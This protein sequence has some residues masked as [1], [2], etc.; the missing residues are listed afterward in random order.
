MRPLPEL[1]RGDIATFLDDIRSGKDPE[2][3]GVISLER[4]R[5]ATELLAGFTELAPHLDLVILD[6]AHALRNKNS[7]SY[8]AWRAIAE[9]AEHVVFLSAT[10]LNLGTDDLFNLVNLLDPDTFPDSKVFQAQL[11]PNQHLNTVARLMADPQG[12][13]HESALRELQLLK[14]TAEGEAVAKRPSF[15]RLIELL[16]SKSTSPD[17]IARIKRYT[18]E[19]NTLGSVFTRTRKV[20]VPEA[21]ALR[22]VEEVLVTW[23]EQEQDLYASIYRLSMRRARD[24]GLPL[25]FAMQMPL[26]QACSSLVVAQRRQLE[27]R[28]WDFRDSDE[29]D[30]EQALDLDADLTE[31]RTIGAD[32]EEAL[33]RTRLNHDTKLDALRSRLRRAKDKGMT[34][35]LIFSFFRGTVAYL[36]E[37]LGGEFRTE[38][39]HGGIQ[40]E[41][42]QKIIDRFRAGEFDLLIAN[43]VGSE[44]LDFEFCNVLVNYDLPWNPM[45]VEQRIGR[46]DRFGQTHPKIHIFNMKTPGTIESDIYGR[47]YSRIGVFERSIGDL[48]PIMRGGLDKLNKTILDPDLR[49]D[50]KIAAI[51][52]FEVATAQERDRVKAIEDESGLIS[53]RILDIEGLSK[54]GPTNGRYIGAAE[55]RMLLEFIVGAKGGSLRSTKDPRLVEILGTNALA[56]A[57]AG[58]HRNASGT[59]YGISSMLGKIRDIAPIVVCFDP[60]HPEIAKHE[61]ITA[62]H[63]LIRL[64]V[65]LLDARADLVPRFGRVA[66]P[67]L[68]AASRCVISL[69]LVRTKGGLH[70]R[71]ELWVTA[72][73][74]DSGALIEE[75]SNAVMTALAE[76]RLM[77]ADIAVSAQQV[78]GRLSTL[79]SAVQTRRTSEQ[80]ER[81]RENDALVAGRVVSEKRSL[82][83]KIDRAVEKLNHGQDRGLAPSM[84]RMAEGELRKYHS[85]MDGIEES[86]ERRRSVVLSVEH[87]AVLIATGS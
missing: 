60:N 17:D 49:D 76:G 34:Q 16:E 73:E 15:E 11:Q 48:E 30:A 81:T 45:Q 7:R 69:D 62:R 59:T 61:L 39:L 54:D 12:R 5:S 41:E 20:D 63:P 27:R 43:Q 1:G 14:A 8:A 18:N 84:I 40:I 74:L 70:D 33:V 13:S 65:E 67:G 23:S 10:P 25:G 57:L 83:I 52:R 3:I 35:A 26:R 53:T 47:L 71:Q 51:D 38:V 79:Q 28:G 9:H 50:Q 6:E 55:L 77:S 44:G 46:L 19:L 4:L 24:S 82:Q 80:S 22:E 29:L 85:L 64:A 36:A 32:L 37:E 75:A 86:L 72:A 68:D 31:S 78:A 42:R 66:V 2:L 21:K 58:Y 56:T 87:V